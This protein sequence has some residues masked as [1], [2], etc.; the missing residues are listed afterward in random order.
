MLRARSTCPSTHG[1][2]LQ[3]LV[4][5]LCE[6]DETLTHAALAVRELP[7]TPDAAAEGLSVVCLEVCYR[8]AGCHACSR[9]LYWTARRAR[10]AVFG[11][12]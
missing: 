6:H 11:Q 3:L 8:P 2:Q 7:G 9:P 5:M 1:E 4:I 12:L 10:H